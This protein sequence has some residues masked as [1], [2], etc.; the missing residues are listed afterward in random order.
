[1]LLVQYQFPLYL[2]AFGLGS[3]ITAVCLCTPSGRRIWLLADLLWVVFGLLG[4]LGAVVAEIYLADSSRVE[5]QIGIARAAMADFDADVSRFRLGHCGAPQT[6]ALGVLCDKA[7]FLAASTAR[8]ADLP[9]FTALTTETSPLRIF[10]PFANPPATEETADRPGRTDG[11]DVRELLTFKPLDDTTRPALESLRE[12][13]PATAANFHILARSYASLVDEIRVLQRDWAYIKR[14]AWLLSL[15]IVAICLVS[16][17]APF[18]LGRAI[19]NL[20][21]TY[22]PD[23]ADHP[24]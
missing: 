23:Q 15:K 7:D 12:T 22:R 1:M 21:A 20:R 6:Q 2:L 5:R 11:R 9:L 4:A 18:R 14:R 8:N 24:S 16:F 10:D 13:E 19:A 17:A 3:A